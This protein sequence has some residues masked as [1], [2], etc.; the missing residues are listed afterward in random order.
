MIFLRHNFVHL[1]GSKNF[2]N[3]PMTS[4]EIAVPAF[5]LP[6]YEIVFPWHAVC[7]IISTCSC[8]AKLNYCLLTWSLLNKSQTTAQPRKKHDRCQRC[9][10]KG[11]LRKYSAF[12]PTF[13]GT[14]PH[15]NTASYSRNLHGNLQLKFL[16]ILNTSWIHV[17][18][19]S[20]ISRVSLPLL[21]VNLL[22]V[23]IFRS[24]QVIYHLLFV[25]SL[26]LWHLVIVLAKRP[27]ASG[28]FSSCA[29]R[30]QD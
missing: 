1:M 15:H 25:V 18:L 30:W 11:M 6:L 7:Y 24:D 29:W 20:V 26:L 21:S 12:G 17:V 9:I 28:R 23:V 13:L 3:C 8:K 16:R 10:R 22:T 4:K 27:S 2:G 19:A 14:K 5:F